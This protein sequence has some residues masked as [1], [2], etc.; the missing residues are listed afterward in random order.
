MEDGVY[1]EILCT[2]PHIIL[3]LAFFYEGSYEDRHFLE[4]N[5]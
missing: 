3:F 2:I 4:K 5:R 1:E